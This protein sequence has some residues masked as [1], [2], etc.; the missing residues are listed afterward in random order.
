MFD[1]HSSPGRATRGN[2]TGC[3]NPRRPT[4][5]T[6]PACLGC[7]GPLGLRDVTRLWPLPLD[8]HRRR[9]PLTRVVGEA[10]CPACRYPNYL[11]FPTSQVTRNPFGLPDELADR[12]SA[13]AVGCLGKGQP[14]AADSFLELARFWSLAHQLSLSGDIHRQPDPRK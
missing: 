6:P 1:S 7:G 3:G 5:A 4:S 8:A 13:Y 11:R 12:L 9:P 14:D 10:V 2:S